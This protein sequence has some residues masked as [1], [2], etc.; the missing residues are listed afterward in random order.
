MKTNM[1]HDHITHHQE[2]QKVREEEG[3]KIIKIVKQSQYSTMS[4]A[5]YYG[6]Q[7]MKQNILEN[8]QSELEQPTV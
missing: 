1:Y 4:D 6:A 3:R 5:H 8:I 2:L 7:G